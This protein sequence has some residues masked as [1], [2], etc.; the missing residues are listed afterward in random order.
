MI[1]NLKKFN[2]H[3]TYHHFKMDTIHTATAMIR[4]NCYMA[5][6]DLKDAY[7][8]VPIHL[9]D[10]KYLKFQ[11]NDTFYKY[12]CFANG[13]SPCP[14]MFTKLLKPVYSVLRQKGHELIG[15]IDDQYIQGDT[16]DSCF[17]S[18]KA[19]IELL[20]SLGLVIHPEKS[21]LVP[22]QTLEFLGFILNSVSMTVSLTEVKKIK[23]KED[24]KFLRDNKQT[25]IR[26][27]A[28]VIGILVLAFPAVQFGPLYYRR[29]EHDKSEAVKLNNGNFDKHMKLSSEASLELEWWEQNVFLSTKPI[30]QPQPDI[31]IYTD[32]SLLDWGA[33]DTS[34]NTKTGGE[35][36]QS[37]RENLHI[38]Y[39]ELKAV[40]FALQSFCQALQNVHV[41]FMVDNT[42]AVAYI[43]EMGGSKSVLCNEMA[44]KIW[45]FAYERKIWISSA[46]VPGKLN[47]IADTESRKFKGLLSSK[48]YFIFFFL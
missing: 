32:A 2:E 23:I 43:R 12:V 22:S 1:L 14:R 45:I 11:W 46:H 7:Y 48:N 28:R 36:L 47:T 31:F 26:E 41:R 19:C 25:T 30:H 40:Y 35:W 39:L 5:S 13:L 29:L 3:L 20:R 33:F 21:A 15:Y 24:C 4:P 42:T 8:S 6:M 18:V 37:D 16:F 27:V 38:N 34:T 9:Q 17:S 10:Q 44:H